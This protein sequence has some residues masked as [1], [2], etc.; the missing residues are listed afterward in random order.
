MSTFLLLSTLVLRS[1]VAIRAHGSRFR[2]VSTFLPLSTLVLRSRVAIRAHGGRLRHVST[3]LLLSTLVLGSPSCCAHV[4]QSVG[5]GG[6]LRQV[7]TFV[8]RSR[9]AIG[10]A[11]AGARMA[12]REH[13]GCQF[14]RDLGDTPRMRGVGGVAPH[15]F[16]SGIVYRVIL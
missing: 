11:R 7:S 6:R 14:V 13:R 1:R 12:T 9:G 5:H 8:R 10:R 3:F 16:K 2:H 15:T 4:S